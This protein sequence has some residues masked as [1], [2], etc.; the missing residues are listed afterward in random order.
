[1]KEI[2]FD[3]D[4]KSAE[5]FAKILEADCIR[6]EIEDGFRASIYLA[7]SALDS[8]KYIAV[9]NALNKLSEEIMILSGRLD[10]VEYL[11]SHVTT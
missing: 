11:S 9:A 2:F 1:M 5:Y 7:N 4:K 8:G 6:S 10:E 3:L